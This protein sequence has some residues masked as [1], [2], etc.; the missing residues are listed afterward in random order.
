MKHYIMLS[1]ITSSGGVQCYVA[2][3]ARYLEEQGWH[4]VVISDNNPKD[5]ER[6]LISSLNKY[7]PNGNPYQ[8]FNAC[9][10]PKIM[11]KKAL[12]RYLKVI[13]PIE[14]GE[15]VIVESWNSPTALWGELIA[16]RLHARHVF[17]TA[18]ET[19]RKGGECIDNCYEEKIDFYKFKMDRGEIFTS[20]NG[21]NRL[22][23]DYRVYK[24]GDFLE[25]IN[26]EDPIQDIDSMAVNS[27]VKADWNI[28]Y[29]GRENKP[30]VPTIFKEVGEFASNHIDKII[31]FVVVGKIV[32]NK[33]ILDEI[34]KLD[35]LKV[36]ELG[37]LYP[38]PRS[39]YSKI[40]VVIAG[41][42]SA[43][44]SADEGALVITADSFMINSHGLLG[45][46]TNESLQKEEGAL[47][48]TFDEALERALVQK[49]WLNQKN[50]WIKSPGIKECTDRQFE[51]ISKA[52]PTLEYY[53]E[54][55]L[56]EGKVDY[57]MPLRIL[58]GRINKF[59]GRY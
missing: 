11:V 17:W 2:A 7:L 9:Y 24:E 55:R 25:S 12:R 18:N 37:D 34:S 54:N 53:D 56:L 43:R 50:N 3:K 16:K 29:I 26:T 44:H 41:S 15:E 4:V 58:H 32:A 47:D 38:I 59:F 33:N 19:F 27:I 39:L 46:D 36:V 1:Y 20:L 23:E 48:M 57:L 52:S 30:Y 5:N 13:C 51:I 31:Q 14:K 22:F 45:F 10:I 21:A 42:G 49:T 40:D 35:N 28:C 8:G 6:C